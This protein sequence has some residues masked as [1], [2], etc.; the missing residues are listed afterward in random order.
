MG[1]ERALLTGGERS[2]GRQRHK[3]KLGSEQGLLRI[4]VPVLAELRCSWEALK[5]GLTRRLLGK[6]GLFSWCSGSTR[7]Q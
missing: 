7:D 6:E 1:K 5:G 3:G 2:W 4:L